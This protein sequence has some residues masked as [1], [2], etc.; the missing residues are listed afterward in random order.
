MILEKS[1]EPD[2][3]FPSSRRTIKRSPI[4]GSRHL[5][6]TIQQKSYHMSCVECVIE[7]RLVCSSAYWRCNLSLWRYADVPPNQYSCQW[8]LGHRISICP[9]CNRGNEC[10][11]LLFLI[12][13]N[14]IGSVTGE[15]VKGDHCLCTFPSDQVFLRH[16]RASSGHLYL[17]KWRGN[18]T[19][20]RSYRFQHFTGASNKDCPP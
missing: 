12:G 15:Q 4:L 20:L 2:E 16:P 6:I 8:G 11:S 5:P 14:G 10:H 1:M 19:G 13:V 17:G 9:Q 3:P 18:Q 7:G